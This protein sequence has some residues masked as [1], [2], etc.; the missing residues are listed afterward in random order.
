M[1]GY[2]GLLGLVYPLGQGLETSEFQHPAFE[3][4]HLPAVHFSGL[5]ELLPL[6]R[7][8]FGNVLFRERLFH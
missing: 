6:A 2:C 8:V 4:L 7:D 3:I 1:L 5:L